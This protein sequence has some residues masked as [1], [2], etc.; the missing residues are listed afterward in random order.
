[1]L[2]VALYELRDLLMIGSAEIQPVSV[3]DS[4]GRV[5]DALLRSAVALEGGPRPALR[6]VRRFVDEMTSDEGPWWSSVLE[7][8]VSDLDTSELRWVEGSWLRFVQD[9]E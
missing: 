6:L 4:G 9:V 2:S 3:F 5:L 8:D 1:M 7:C